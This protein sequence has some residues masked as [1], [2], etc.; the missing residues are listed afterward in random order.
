VRSFEDWQIAGLADSKIAV[1]I[2][3]TVVNDMLAHAREE[4]PRECCG[5]LIG[6]D[7]IV[8]RAMRARNTDDVPTRRYLIDPADH[9][10][11]IRAAREL[12]REVIG[13]YHS[14]PSSVPVPS[15]TDL[16]EADNGSEFLYVIVSPWNG[17]VRAYRYDRDGFRNCPLTLIP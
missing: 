15:P 4:A 11:A 14:H 7:G 13:A 6:R 17:D 3:A 1:K 8:E 16:A 5:L 12:R 2:P 10:A 9:F